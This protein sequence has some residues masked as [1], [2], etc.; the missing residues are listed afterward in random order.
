MTD[1]SDVPIFD[2]GDEEEVD[3]KT[4]R[5]RFQKEW[6]DDSASQLPQSFGFSDDRDLRASLSPLSTHIKA[7]LLRSRTSLTP[8]GLSTPFCRHSSSHSYVH[9]WTRFKSWT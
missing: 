1:V 7:R 9:Q 4:R 2:D 6:Y 8:N 5:I 3:S